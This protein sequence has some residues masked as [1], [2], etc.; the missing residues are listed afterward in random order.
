MRGL[1][2]RQAH[3]DHFFENEREAY[4]DLFENDFTASADLRARQLVLAWRLDSLWWAL[5]TKCGASGSVAA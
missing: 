1:T 2:P 4:T 5:R 3:T